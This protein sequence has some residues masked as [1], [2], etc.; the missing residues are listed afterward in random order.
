MLEWGKEILIIFQKFR[1]SFSL[2]LLWLDVSDSFLS[3]LVKKFF[4]MRFLVES[5][6]I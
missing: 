5:S 1:N 2:E 3:V 4:N 6:K